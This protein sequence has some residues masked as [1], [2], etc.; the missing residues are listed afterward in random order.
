MN[1]DGGQDAGRDAKREAMSS[2]DEAADAYLASD[3]HRAGEDLNTLAEWSADASRALDVACGAGHTAN[4]LVEAG[5]PSVVAA[6]ATPKM[7]RT[8]TANF[9]VAGA[10]ADAE[11]L[12]FR[13]GS[14]DAAT[15]RVAAHHFPDP[16]AFVRE[17]Y[18]VLAPGGTFAFEDVA[19][20]EDSELADFTDRFETLRDGSHVKAHPQSQW[21]AWLRDGGFEIEVSTVGR[22]D[23]DFAD[24]VDRTDPLAADR[25]RLDELVRT[26]E[27]AD[28]YEV[29][30]EDDEVVE[31]SNVK[32][33]MRA[34]KPA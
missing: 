25:E 21:A 4:A 9:P 19:A 11:R 10:V 20:P 5:V 27:A 1:S 15:C 12:P 33:L 22:I 28:A 34:R 18:R 32:V 3:V 14:F 26:P 29:E 17:V 16:E 7:V 6:D 31:F 30:V 24:W 13:T 8:A 23:L 2:F